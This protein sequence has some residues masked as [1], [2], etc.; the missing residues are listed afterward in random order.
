MDCFLG[1]FLGENSQINTRKKKHTVFCAN[2]FFNLDEFILLFPKHLF[3]F[4]ISKVGTF[5]KVIMDS[6]K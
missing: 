5:I 4:Q 2:F 3:L 1:K 6:V